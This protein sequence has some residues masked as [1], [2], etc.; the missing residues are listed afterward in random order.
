MTVF[1]QSHSGTKLFPLPKKKKKKNGKINQ[2]LTEKM[3][4]IRF[5]KAT[6]HT[7]M[8]VIL[9]FL[10]HFGEWYDLPQEFTFHLAEHHRFT[11]EI[12]C[13]GIF[14]LVTFKTDVSHPPTKNTKE[15]CPSPFLI[16]AAMLNICTTSCWEKSW[17][18]SQQ[19][20]HFHQC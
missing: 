10:P 16:L 1:I 14:F 13:W 15:W 12:A 20:N 4:Y 8:I 7:P 6:T 17:L 18:K 11:H 19:A 5:Y 3:E 2:R 9:P